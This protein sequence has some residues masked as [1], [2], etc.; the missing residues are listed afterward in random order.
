MKQR[1]A[2]GVKEFMQRTT[3]WDVRS[4]I[5]F[6]SESGR[7]VHSIVSPDWCPI[8]PSEPSVPQ[9]ELT[10]W[11]PQSPNLLTS[12]TSLDEDFWMTRE[13]TNVFRNK[14]LLKK[15]YTTM[16]ERSEE[17]FYRDYCPIKWCYESD[18]NWAYLDE[19]LGKYKT[20]DNFSFCVGNFA[21]SI[22]TVRPAIIRRAKKYGMEVRSPKYKRVILWARYSFLQSSYSGRCT[23]NYIR[24]M[25]EKALRYGIPSYQQH[26]ELILKRL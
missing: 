23:I 22:E 15:V 1:S 13:I 6:I 7:D 16:I 9:C 21:L 10:P 2:K 19:T 11:L 24:Y 12:I 17:R 18:I 26:I 4:Q 25:G 3:G 14:A 20:E 5:R 8:G